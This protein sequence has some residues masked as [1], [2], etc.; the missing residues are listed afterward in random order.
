MSVYEPDPKIYIAYE[1]AAFTGIHDAGLR[2]T[3][4]E[5]IRFRTNDLSFDSGDYGTQILASS[6]VLMEIKTIMAMPVW[7]STA[8]NE[9]KIYPGS[10]SKYGH[11][12]K[13]YILAGQLGTA[14]STPASK[15]VA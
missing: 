2:I 10:F 6:N 4:D 12:Y 7:L 9:L 3:F 1:R 15:T 8:L 14:N 11:C 5:N 13:N